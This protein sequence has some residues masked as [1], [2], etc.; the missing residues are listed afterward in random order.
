MTTYT[1]RPLEWKP[2]QPLHEEGEIAETP[3]GNYEVYD[4]Y[5]GNYIAEFAHGGSNCIVPIC[6]I[7]GV[8]FEQAKAACEQH[9]HETI[10]QALV[11]V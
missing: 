6:R 8:S 11:K 3:F 5:N 1:I 10:K 7:K 4:H 9:Y 2:F